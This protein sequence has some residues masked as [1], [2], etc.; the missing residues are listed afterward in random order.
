VVKKLGTRHRAGWGV[1]AE[2]DAVSIVISEETGNVTVFHD[3]KMTSVGSA[4]ELKDILM[5]LF[6]RGGKK[7][8]SES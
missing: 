5:K 8:G 3:R 2:T 7:R 4:M 6:T 1:S